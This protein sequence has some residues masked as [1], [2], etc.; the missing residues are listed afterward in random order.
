MMGPRLS[1]AG[2][3]PDRK[4]SKENQLRNEKEKKQI[5]FQ[6]VLLVNLKIK[7]QN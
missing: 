5:R 1:A 3:R 4:P 2:V 7:Q 6:A